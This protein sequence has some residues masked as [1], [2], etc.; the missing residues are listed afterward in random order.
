MVYAAPEMIPPSICSDAP[1]AKQLRLMCTALV[2][3]SVK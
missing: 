1:L 2:F 3:F